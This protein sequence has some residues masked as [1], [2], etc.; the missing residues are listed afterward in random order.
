[1]STLS[2]RAP[3]VPQVWSSLARVAA[4]IAS[5]LDFLA[6]TRLRELAAHNRLPFADW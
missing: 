6:E 1:M 4:T 5:A 3:H 2:L